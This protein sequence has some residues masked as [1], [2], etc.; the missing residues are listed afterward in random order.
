[1]LGEE[2]LYLSTRDLAERIRAR[3][4]SPVELTQSYL[5]RSKRLG[6]RLNAYVTITED[7]ALAQARATEKEIA[8]GHYRGPLHGIP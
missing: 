7:L 6:P 3:K 4:I 2:I 8:A 1:M 5:E